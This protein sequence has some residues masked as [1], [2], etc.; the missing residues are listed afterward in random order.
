[1]LAIGLAFVL[2]LNKPAAL[3]GT[4]VSNPLFAPFLIFFGLETGSWLL[5]ARPAHLSLGDIKHHFQS[6]DFMDLMSEYLLPY[7][8][9]SLVVAVLLAFLTFWASL[10]IARS[11]RRVN[12]QTE[13]PPFG[14][15]PA[16]P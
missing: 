6:P 11:Y 8:V 7:V 10:W 2:G 15:S 5:Y 9:G 13:G 4:L 1:M 3:F 14:D 16:A 12:Q